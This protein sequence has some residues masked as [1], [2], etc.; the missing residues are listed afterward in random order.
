MQFK[1]VQRIYFTNSKL[2][3]MYYNIAD[4]CNRCHMTLANM[5]HM[6]WSCIRLQDYRTA[7]FNH[8]AEALNTKSTPCAELAIFGVLSD[9]QTIR[10]KVKDSIVSASLLAHRRILLEWKSP[11]VPKASL[12]LKDLP[13]HL[14][15]LTS[16][17][18][19]LPSLPQSN[20]L[21]KILLCMLFCSMY[22][23]I[24]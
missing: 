24:W 9:P 4:T 6:F 15:Q 18:I 20:P 22:L 14:W 8:L 2:S 16:H 21:T 1:V 23:F 17:H 13:P 5:T 7:T 10:R 3:K 12:W 11:F 19:S